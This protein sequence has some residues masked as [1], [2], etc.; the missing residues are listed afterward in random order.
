MKWSAIYGFDSVLLV[1][2]LDKGKTECV[3]YG[4]IQRLKDAPG[5]KIAING[6]EVSNKDYFKKVSHGKGTRGDTISLKLSSVKL[7]V[8]GKVFSS[9]G[10]GF[11]THYRTN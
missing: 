11:S 3:L 1:L 6:T 8:F 10:A 2:N 4:T 9:K 7:E 5:V